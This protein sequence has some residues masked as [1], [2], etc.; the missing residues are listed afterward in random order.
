M[1][2]L[3]GPFQIINIHS[4]SSTDRNLECRNYET[5]LGIAAAFNW[6]SFS[7]KQCIGEIDPHISWRVRHIIKR[8][9]LGKFLCKKQP[10]IG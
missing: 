9:S 5:C 10:H 6:E 1:K 2:R 4:C 8:D 7:C 3:R